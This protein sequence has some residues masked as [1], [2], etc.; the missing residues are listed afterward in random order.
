[1]STGDYGGQKRPSASLELKLGQ[2]VM[3]SLM[4]VLGTKL[5][6]LCNNRQHPEPFLQLPRVISDT[7]SIL[8]RDSPHSQNTGRWVCHSQLLADLLTSHIQ[9]FIDSHPQGRETSKL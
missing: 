5:G 9:R 2:G 7:L 1:M 8:I 6:A 3:N 4:R